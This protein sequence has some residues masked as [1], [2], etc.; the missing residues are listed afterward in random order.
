[1]QSRIRFTSLRLRL[2]VVFGLVALTAAVSASGIAYW[3]N[4][5]A[6]QTRAQDAAL[7]D[8]EREMQ[9]HVSTLRPNPTQDQLRIAARKM[10]DG[11]ERSSVLLLAEGADGRTVSGSSTDNALTGFSLDDVAKRP[12][13][14][15]STS[16]RS[17]RR[18]TGTRTTCTGSGSS[19]AT[20]R[21]WW[22][23]RR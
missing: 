11:G 19:T 14:R 4:R 1:M 16:G 8:F 5:E 20:P 22:A 7:N 6:V 12:S 2:V 17:S 18:A 15:P 23:A 10:A 9:S 21:I 3:L 13:R